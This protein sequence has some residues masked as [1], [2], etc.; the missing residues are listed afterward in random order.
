M[1]VCVFCCVRELLWTLLE[2]GEV[3][4][5]QEKLCLLSAE[6]NCRKTAITSEHRFAMYNCNY[7]TVFRLNAN[8]S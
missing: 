4:R 2:R 5:L 7:S 6:V 1:C 8:V 3:L